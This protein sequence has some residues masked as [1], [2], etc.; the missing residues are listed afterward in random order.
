MDWKSFLSTV[1]K[2]LL[3]SDDLLEKFSASSSSW[4]GFYAI[5]DDEIQKHATRLGT[6]FPPSYIE[7]LKTSNSFKQLSIIVK[8]TSTFL[9]LVLVAPKPPKGGFK[10]PSKQDLSILIPGRT[11]YF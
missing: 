2:T 4:L 6:D 9:P 10:T 11:I 3:E 5:T 1:S 7:F 8:I